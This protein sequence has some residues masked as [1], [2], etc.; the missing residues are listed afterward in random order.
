MTLEE[1]SS[2]V[3]ALARVLYVNGLSTDQTLSEAE[4]L[5]DALGLRAKIMARWGE[6]QLQA[7]DGDARLIGAIAADP[8]GVN[9]ARVASATRAME[10][11]RAGRL[12]PTAASEGA[13]FVRGARSRD[14]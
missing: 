7:E 5:G 2:L 8:S 3:L 10:E 9:M 6:L 14:Q 12:A 4:R 11:L 1:R 13:P